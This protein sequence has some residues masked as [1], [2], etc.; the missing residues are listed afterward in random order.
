MVYWKYKRPMSGRIAVY[1]F[2]QRLFHYMK[3]TVQILKQLVDNFFL[4]MKWTSYRSHR[5]F[6]IENFIY[7]SINFCFIAGGVFLSPD[8][9]NVYTTLEPTMSSNPNVYFQRGAGVHPG[10]MYW[11]T[12]LFAAVLTASIMF[13]FSP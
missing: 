10:M 13:L 2:S 4:W 12:K 1:V 3:L 11:K 7:T 6:L 8:D 9:G 5:H